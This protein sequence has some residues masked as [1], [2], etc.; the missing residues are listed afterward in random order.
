VTGTG[1]RRLTDPSL[2][3]G[4]WRGSRA[5]RRRSR[6]LRALPVQ[7][8]GQSPVRL[9]QRT[10]SAV[11]LRRSRTGCTRRTGQRAAPT[12]QTVLDGTRAR[13]D[14][15]AAP[16]LVH[17][18]DEAWLALAGE[19]AA[20]ATARST[21]MSLPERFEWTPTWAGSGDGAARRG[22]QAV[23]LAKES[24]PGSPTR[25]EA[26]IVATLPADESDRIR[27]LA[28]AR[29]PVAASAGFTVAE[30]SERSVEVIDLRGA[31]RCDAAGSAMARCVSAPTGACSGRRCP[32]FSAGRAALARGGV[33]DPP[34][35]AVRVGVAAAACRFEPTCSVYAGRRR[36]SATPLRRVARGAANPEV[37]PLPS[38]GVTRFR[39]GATLLREST[40][41]AEPESTCV[42][43]TVTPTPSVPVPVPDVTSQSGTGSPRSTRNGHR[44]EPNG[45]VR[46]RLGRGREALNGLRAYVDAGQG[47]SGGGRADRTTPAA[48]YA[49][50]R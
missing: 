5:D 19:G 36:L 39:R 37:P 4:R 15:D 20:P 2:D 22:A 6:R 17:T 12:H 44:E 11:Y 9:L 21:W 16:I 23:E 34:L 38:G 48:N 43:A 40:K 10:M 1:S 14:P 29:G 46:D 27:P 32:R 42:T 41:H 31:A 30:G 3:A 26:G 24:S 7:P 33:P 28:A 18:A 47:P 45:G 25:S 49:A 50:D 35:Q 8:G 13:A